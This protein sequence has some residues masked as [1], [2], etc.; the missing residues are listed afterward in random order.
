M[1]E[2]I[3]SCCSTADLS[4]EYLEQRD[5][6]YVC[7]HY[8]LNG[9]D[10]PDDLGKTMPISEFYKKM[11]EGAEPTT[12]QVSVGQYAEYF[13]ELLKQGKPILHITLSSGISGSY[14]SA[15]IA[16][17]DILEKHPD[18]NIV[19][20]DSLAA[21]SGFGLVVALAAD[22]RDNGKSIEE[23][24]AFVEENKLRVHHWFFSTDLTS[25]VRGGRVSAAAGWFGTML[26]ICP[27]L[28][29]NFEGKLIPRTK[30]RG[31]KKVMDEMLSKMV[32]FAD[33][34]ADY[35]GKCFMS[36]SAC[37]DDANEVA[38]M[39]EEK[40]PKLKGKIIINNIGTVIGAHTGPGTVALFFTGAKRTD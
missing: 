18:A 22:E 9:K 25:Y 27:L 13:E 7:F 12:S 19:I 39:I 4:R 21:S 33:N 15:K 38:A 34:G 1:S 30:C 17:E 14:N 26:H 2:F 31:K 5:I 6:S 40:F 29:V 37:I 11:S 8:N 28:N 32:Q 36:N 24:A 35:D 23:V 3:L 20:L 16:R 10:Y